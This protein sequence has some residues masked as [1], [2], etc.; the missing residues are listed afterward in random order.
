VD[1]LPEPRV[2]TVLG[3]TVPL[4]AQAPFEAS[5]AAKLHLARRALAA[6]SPGGIAVVDRL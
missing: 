4:L 2:E 1:R 6:P 5:A 3:L